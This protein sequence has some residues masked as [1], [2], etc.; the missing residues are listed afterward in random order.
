MV[1]KV[2]RVAVSFHGIGVRNP[3]PLVRDCLQNQ[4]ETRTNGR[5]IRGS[6]SKGHRDGYSIPNLP[7]TRASEPSV[8][9]SEID[10]KT[11]C[12]NIAQNVKCL[13]ARLTGNQETRLQSPARASNF[14][15]FEH[16]GYLAFLIRLDK[17]KWDQYS[18]LWILEKIRYGLRFFLE[19]GEICI[20]SG[21][22][23][24]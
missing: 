7:G 1:V 15:F 9:W 23:N 20:C 19:S 2:R 24:E 16:S 6:R 13:I 17:S 21:S 4:M 10:R 11:S 12:K 18:S 3:D 14:S 5:K 22:N 8:L